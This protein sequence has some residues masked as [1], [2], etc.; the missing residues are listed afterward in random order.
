MAAAV[1]P[2]PRPRD[3]EP[4]PAPLPAD[5]ELAVVLNPAKVEDPA[6]FRA[7]V[8]PRAAELGWGTRCGSRRPSRTRAARWPTTA[9]VGG[10]ELVAGLR[11]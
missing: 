7:L 10:A 6:A 5:A 11:R 2:T 8:E 9:A 3:V 1:D 4:L